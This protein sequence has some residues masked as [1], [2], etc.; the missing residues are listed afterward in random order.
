MDKMN[1]FAEASEDDKIRQAD[2]EKFIQYNHVG[3]GGCKSVVK[4]I[5][6]FRFF[7]VRDVEYVQSA[8]TIRSLFENGYCYYFAKILEEAFPGGTICLCYPYGHIVYV[9]KEVAYDIG[10][11]SDAEAE[12]YVPIDAV[13]EAGIIVFKHLPGPPIVLTELEKVSVKHYCEETG[14]AYA[15]SDC[16]PCRQAVQRCREIVFGSDDP[17]I[18]K[19][20]EALESIRC[21]LHTYSRGID[22][23][24]DMAIYCMKNKLSWELIKMLHREHN[25]QLRKEAR[26]SKNTN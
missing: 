5:A 15:L 19:Q 21:E 20:R 17:E 26:F 13:P 16:L 14:G 11:V 4:F 12:Y 24:R 3:C 8:E 18:Q 6:N 22:F 23:D 7:A 25:E 2:K 9:Y 10:G 1:F